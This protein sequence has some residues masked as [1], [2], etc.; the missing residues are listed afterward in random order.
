MRK[1]TESINNDIFEDVDILKSMLAEYND[2]GMKANIKYHIQRNYEGNLFAIK[3]S[4]KEI[5]E[6]ENIQ[7]EDPYIKCYIISF[8][9]IADILTS[10]A[11]R[12][13]DRRMFFI[14]PDKLYKFIQITEDLQSKIEGYGHTFTLS[15]RDS[16]FDFMILKG[17]QD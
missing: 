3:T 4:D 1:F 7:T 16:E 2:I 15:T 12:D 17:K 9:E 11:Q 14:P 5:K 6:Y 8:S 10:S 13:P